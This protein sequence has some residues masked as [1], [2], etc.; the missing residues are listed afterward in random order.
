MIREIHPLRSKIPSSWF[1][2]SGPGVTQ[3]AKDAVM[4]MNQ[5]EREFAITRGWIPPQWREL[6]YRRPQRF[7]AGAIPLH[8][9]DVSVDRIE[10]PTKKPWTRR[11]AGWIRGLFGGRS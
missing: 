3:K 10:H 1:T 11:F 7:S 5:S 6:P 2:K 9:H 8:D 4:T